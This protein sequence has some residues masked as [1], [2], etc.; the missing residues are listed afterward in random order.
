MPGKPTVALLVL[1]LVLAAPVAA[2]AQA[3]RPGSP[4]AQLEALARPAIHETGGTLFENVA[5]V[6]AANYVDKDFRARELPALIEQ[7][8]PK[9]EAAASLLEQRQ[10]VQEFLSH[11]PAS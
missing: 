11:I 5:K 4:E 6:L 8:R 2:G 9:A 1:S 7:Y 10:V 3:L